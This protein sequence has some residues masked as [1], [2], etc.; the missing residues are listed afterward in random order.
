MEVNRVRLKCF[1]HVKERDEGKFTTDI[2][3]T[4]EFGVRGKGTPKR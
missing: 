2:Y 1:G 3:R 4:E